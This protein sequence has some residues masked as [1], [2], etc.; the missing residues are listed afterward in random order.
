MAETQWVPLSVSIVG[1]LDVWDYLYAPLSELLNSRQEAIARGLREQGSDDFLLAEIECDRLV[2]LAWMEESRF[3]AD[4][5]AN[6]A[7]ALG[8]RFVPATPTEEKP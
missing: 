3:D 1:N 8:Y 7:A 6:A 2:Q 4:E 5:A